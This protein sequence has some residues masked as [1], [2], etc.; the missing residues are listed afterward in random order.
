MINHSKSGKARTLRDIGCKQAIEW[1]F[2]QSLRNVMAAGRV[3]GAAR[4]V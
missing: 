2:Q 4:L 3:R 1:M